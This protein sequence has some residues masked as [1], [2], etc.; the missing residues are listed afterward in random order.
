MRRGEV[1]TVAGGKDDAGKPRPVVIVQDYGF[2]TT[3][4]VTVAFVCPAPASH[5]KWRR[6]VRPSTGLPVRFG[7]N[8]GF[9]RAVA[10]PAAHHEALALP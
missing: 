6:I 8:R 2:D 5:G 3:A 1:W 7:G 4:S 10:G 9:R